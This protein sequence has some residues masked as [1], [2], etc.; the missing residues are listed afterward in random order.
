MYFSLAL[1]LYQN[2]KER[3]TDFLNNYGISY[4]TSRIK[5]E[6]RQAYEKGLIYGRRVNLDKQIPGQARS[7]RVIGNADQ[8]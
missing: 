5:V 4:T 8:A 7:T 2:E 1:V 3:I 6:R